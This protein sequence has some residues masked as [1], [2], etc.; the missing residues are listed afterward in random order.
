MPDPR[1]RPLKLRRARGQ[2]LCLRLAAGETLV[3]AARAAGVDAEEAAACLADE[4]FQLFVATARQTQALGAAELRRQALVLARHRLMAALIE[5]HL[6]V[7]LLTLA[8]EA[9]GRDPVVTVAERVVARILRTP[10]LRPPP[11]PRP[12]AAP[13]TGH[14]PVRQPGRDI[15]N[16]RAQLVDR[17]VQDLIPAPAPWSQDDRRA[18]LQ[19]GLIGRPQ[20]AQPQPARLQP[21]E[22]AGGPVGEPAGGPAEE[23]DRSRAAA[24][25]PMG[26][27]GEAAPAGTSLPAAEAPRGTPEYAPPAVPA[28]PAARALLALARLPD[29]VLA[30]LRRHRP[31]AR[32]G[33]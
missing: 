4:A 11:P 18:A 17:V 22:P 20:P 7:T 32:D 14:D 33:P 31:P 21:A 8:E 29:A 30:T 28:A 1:A 25:R 15:G 10:A 26:A 23:V 9:Q 6:G 3:L 2:V 16:A 19:S 5:G 24:L 13:L 27:A 12:A